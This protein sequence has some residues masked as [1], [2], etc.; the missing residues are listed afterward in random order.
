RRPRRRAALDPH[1]AAFEQAAD[2]FRARRARGLLEK[3]CLVG[4]H[5]RPELDLLQPP[6]VD[7]RAVREHDRADHGTVKLGS[8]G[9]VTDVSRSIPSFSSLRCWIAIAFAFASRSGRAWY[10]EGQ[11]RKT[12]NA[13]ASWPASL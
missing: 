6:P 2:E 7:E 5:R 9:S 3:P 1:D 11:A 10:S 12:L 4:S 13:S 8:T